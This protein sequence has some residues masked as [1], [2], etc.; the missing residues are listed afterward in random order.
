MRIRTTRAVTLPGGAER[1]KLSRT[2]TPGRVGYAKVTFSSSIW[3]TVSAG[4]SPNSSK[5]L[6][7]DSRSISVKSCAAD[8][9]ALAKSIEYGARV[10]RLMAAMT[11]ESRTLEQ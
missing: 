1:E 2:V 3:P 9:P 7:S 6:I 4:C 11:T 5:G 10:V 8:E